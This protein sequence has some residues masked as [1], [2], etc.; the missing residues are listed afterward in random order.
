MA[1]GTLPLLVLKTD[2]R[3]EPSDASDCESKR[4]TSTF[5]GSV[6]DISV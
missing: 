6:D 5:A 3:Y 2:R 4:N 1:S